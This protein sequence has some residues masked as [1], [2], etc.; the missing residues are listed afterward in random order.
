[1]RPITIKKLH[2]KYKKKLVQL[3]PL[4]RLEIKEQACTPITY[5]RG[6]NVSG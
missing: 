3:N 5:E 6:F 2:F 1:M 4:T